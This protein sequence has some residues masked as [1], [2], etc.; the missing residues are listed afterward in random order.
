MA[1]IIK[2]PNTA[3][4]EFVNGTK[5]AKEM[6]KEKKT[7]EEFLNYRLN[8]PD[9]NEYNLAEKDVEILALFGEHMKLAPIVAARLTAK[10]AEILCKI[11]NSDPWDEL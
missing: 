1:D 10:L 2:F 3:E 11:K 7:T 9:W 4:K 5:L 6:D 8:F